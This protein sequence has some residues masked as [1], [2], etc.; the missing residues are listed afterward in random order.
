MLQVRQKGKDGKRKRREYGETFQVFDETNEDFD[1][2]MNQTWVGI[3]RDTGQTS[4]RGRHGNG[5]IKS[6]KRYNG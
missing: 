1:G 3:K 4:L 2:G 6:A 5:C